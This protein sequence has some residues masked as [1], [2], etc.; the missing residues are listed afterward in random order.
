VASGDPFAKSVILWTRV[1]LPSG[2]GKNK[3]AFL[4]Y[5]VSTTKKF[6][7]CVTRGTTLTDAAVDF[8]VKV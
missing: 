7:K 8:T 6:Q 1:T 4:D 5:C 2:A 3:P